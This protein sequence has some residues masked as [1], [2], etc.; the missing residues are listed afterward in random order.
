MLPGRFPIHDLSDIG[1]ELP[2]GDY[3]T[4]AGLVL[5]SLGKIPAPGDEATID[6]WRFR[7]RSMRGRAIIEVSLTPT[8]DRPPG[9]SPL[10]EETDGEPA[11]E[12]PHPNR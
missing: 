11:V 1:V 7:V 4:I 12:Q 3:T 5:D 9:P 8:T 10:A 6:G 2:D